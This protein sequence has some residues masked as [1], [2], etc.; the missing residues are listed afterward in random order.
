MTKPPS[1]SPGLVREGLARQ[2]TGVALKDESGGQSPGG[3]ERDDP[4]IR[5]I[6]VVNGAD[7]RVPARLRDVA[8]TCYTPSRQFTACFQG[9]API[10]QGRLQPHSRPGTQAI[11]IEP[12]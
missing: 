12:T 8:Q 4:V 6:I 2:V 9:L 5:P 11:Q 1:R 7:W 3:I 10:R